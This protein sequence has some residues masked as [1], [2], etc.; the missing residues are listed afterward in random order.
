LHDLLELFKS[1]PP[2]PT[3]ETLTHSMSMDHTPTNNTSVVPPLRTGGISA[4]DNMVPNNFPELENKSL[5]ALTEL[6]NDKDKF[7]EFVSNLEATKVTL[8]LQKEVVQR[9]KKLAEKNLS[10]ERELE[11]IK[12]NIDDIQGTIQDLREIYN[13]KAKQK[14]EIA[15]RFSTE[16]ILRRLS[17]AATEA[18]KESE[19][20]SNEFLKSDLI[21]QQNAT[22]FIQDYSRKRKLYHLRTEKVK[23]MKEGKY[24]LKA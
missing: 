14:E 2:I 23:Q 9:N 6:I 20:L 24:P 5:E 4:S 15:K 17:N 22:Q 16:N 10:T 8:N 1:E 18:D 19:D 11:E 12:R 7:L 13:N 3:G 21:V